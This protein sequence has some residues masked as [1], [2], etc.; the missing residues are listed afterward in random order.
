M[1]QQL[2]LSNTRNKV[3]AS[4]IDNFKYEGYHKV[5]CISKELGYRNNR[6]TRRRGCIPEFHRVYVSF[7]EVCATTTG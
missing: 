3:I 6:G 2:M 7:G 5:K 1:H 4:K